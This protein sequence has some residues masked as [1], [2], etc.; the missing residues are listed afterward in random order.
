MIM[1]IKASESVMVNFSFPILDHPEST[2]EIAS[3]ARRDALMSGMRLFSLQTEFAKTIQPIP[4]G[5]VD[6]GD[7]KAKQGTIVKGIDVDEKGNPLAK[8]A[9]GIIIEHHEI[10]EDVLQV[11]LRFATLTDEKGEFSFTPSLGRYRV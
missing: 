5:D 7:I 4:D 11:P 2:Q 6:F 9:V 3:R 8:K 10:L 1:P